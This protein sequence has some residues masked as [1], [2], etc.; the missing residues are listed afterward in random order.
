MMSQDFVNSESV[1]TVRLDMP[2]GTTQPAPLAA[3]PAGALAQS[4]TPTG[5]QST[6]VNVNINST[7]LVVVPSSSGPSFLVRAL[8]YLFIGW[9]LAGLAIGLGYLA[10]FSI[11]G[12]PLAFYIFN[13]I[14][15]LLTLRPRTQN[16]KV[17]VQHG[18]TVLQTGTREQL[19]LWMRSLWF[20]CVGW[21]AGALWL[22]GAYLLSLVIVTLPL[23]LMMFNRVGGVMTLLRY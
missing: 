23:G 8:W 4:S 12:L 17:E 18:V 3:A 5:S 19:P 6:V 20:V 13:R 1:Q 10:V 16:Y 22:T 15:T 14:P 2:A 9:W 11:V 7:P 21:W